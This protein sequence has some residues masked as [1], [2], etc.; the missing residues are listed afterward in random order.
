SKESACC[1]KH[2]HRYY[3]QSASHDCRTPCPHKCCFTQLS[4]IA[5]TVN[6]ENLLQPEATCQ[7]SPLAATNASSMIH[8]PVGA[9]M[10]LR[11]QTFTS[12]HSR[13]QRHAADAFE[14]R[15]CA[16]LQ[17]TMQCTNYEQAGCCEGAL[18]ISGVLIRRSIR[19]HSTV[20]VYAN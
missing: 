5:N 2:Q 17:L 4:S 13:A 15:D 8:A 10:L 9:K 3:R 16:A 6:F 20:L 1:L 11:A 12:L 14:R 7:P 19:L 18:Q